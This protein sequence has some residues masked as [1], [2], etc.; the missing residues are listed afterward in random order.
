MVRESDAVEIIL[1]FRSKGIQIYL[2]GGWG[3]DAL[4]GFESRCHNDID[5]FIEKQDKECSIK[6]LKDTGYSETVM[7]YTT[8]EHTVWRDENAR[9]ID[10]HIFSRNSE[11]DFVFE[12]ETFP[13]E[14]FTSIGR[15]GHLEVDCITPEWQVR[16]HSGYKLDDNDIKDVLLLCDKFNLALPDEIAQNFKINTNRLTLRRWRENDAEALYKYASDGRVSEMA[17]WPRH[18]SV[19]MSRE[20]IK[21]FF[22]PNPFTLAMVL[23]ETNEPIGC[24]GLVPAGAEHYRPFANEREVGYWIGFP[25]WGKGLTS[26]ALKSMIEFCRNNIRLDSLLITTD[27]ANKASQRV[28]E[29]CGFINF[30][31]YDNNGTP[32]KA[33]RLS[34][35]SLVIRKVEDDKQEF[36]DLLLIGDGSVDMIVRYLEPG[37]LHVGS[38]DNK[39]IAVI[40][41]VENNDGSVEIKNLAVDA[42]FRR[43][44]IGRKMLEYVEKLYPDKKIILGTGETPSTLRFYRSCGY[45][46]SHRIPNFFT[47][48]YPN[49]IVE[50]DVTLRD[51]VYLYKDFNKNDTEE[52]S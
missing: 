11:G 41:T 39:D 43:R 44:G 32:S 17:L 52:H 49:P 10:F 27:A 23:K 36:M 1:L 21:D 12:S 15:I 18:T 48:N 46:N 35:S 19:D 4:V 3:V 7:E 24:I 38:M 30:T 31:D 34:L 33:F 45:R 9:I 22:Q 5:I 14:I 50:E 42:A 13:K 6:L 29:K 26:E 2:D 28:A 47:D 8:P 20:V 51:M 16:F 37:S 25:Y 40:V